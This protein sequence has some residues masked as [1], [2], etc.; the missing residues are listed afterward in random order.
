M[1]MPGPLRGSTMLFGQVGSVYLVVHSEMPPSDADWDAWLQEMAREASM[2]HAMLIYT[3]GGG[4]DARQR[5]RTA[6]MWRRH[7]RIPPIA[8]VTTSPIARAMI[9]ALNYFL[10]KPIRGYTPS[11]VEEALGEHLKVPVEEHANVRRAVY[12]ALDALRTTTNSP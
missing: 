10:S 8:V 4:P 11:E 6:E 1:I 2:L 7:P 9:T 12:W 3:E 5:R